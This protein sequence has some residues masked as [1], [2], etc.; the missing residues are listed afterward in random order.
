MKK[1]S[2]LLILIAVI[3]GLS[4]CKSSTD[5]AGWSSSEVDKW[6]EKH[7]W[8]NG[9]NVTPDASINKKELSLHYFKNRER[10]DKAF[11]FLKDNK[12]LLP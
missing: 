8:L 11:A 3:T 5:P 12:Y 1:L 7:E 4:G 2:V 6:F 9:W 10:W